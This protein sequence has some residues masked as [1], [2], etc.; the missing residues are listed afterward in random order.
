LKNFSEL[1][2]KIKKT[3]CLIFILLGVLILIIA[4]PTQSSTESKETAST[5]SDQLAGVL[6][7][8]EGVGQVQVMISFS[9]EKQLE[10]RGV[11]V[12]AEGGDSPQAEEK[13]RNA[14][15]SLFDIEAHKITVVK[16]SEQEE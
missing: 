4:V 2:Q 7:G 10:V 1:L 3:D 11:V 16:M 13:I 9:D 15:M 5:V 14:V 6:S 12:V 8:M